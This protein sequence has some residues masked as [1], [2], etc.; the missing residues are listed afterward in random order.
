M[1]R[2]VAV[3]AVGATLPIV[4]GPAHAAGDEE[5]VRAVLDGMNGSYNR[6]DFASFAAHVCPALRDAEDFEKSWYASRE[7]DGPTRIAIDSVTLAGSP[8]AAA[9]ATVRFA[10]ANQ[11]N[12]K[13]FD[14]DFFREGSEWKACQYHPAK[15]V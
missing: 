3:L 1:R 14:I 7:A 8:A 10:A 4:A 13:T 2:L 6:S 5:Q 15:D 9:V 11:P 12:P